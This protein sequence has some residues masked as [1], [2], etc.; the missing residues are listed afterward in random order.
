[1]MRN[2]KQLDTVIEEE[3]NR[4]DAQ[5]LKNSSYIS[6]DDSS[7]MSASEVRE[8]LSPTRKMASLSRI[9]DDINI[10]RL[11]AVSKRINMQKDDLK[12]T[13]IIFEKDEELILLQK[14]CQL[15]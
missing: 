3:T 15:F 8:A 4:L 9:D 5:P 14:K 11:N 2:S 13:S 1:M 7:R 6:K 10:E 12:L